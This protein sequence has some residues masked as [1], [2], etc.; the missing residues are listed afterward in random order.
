MDDLKS[1]VE[2][3]EQALRSIEDQLGR[4]VEN[5]DKLDRKGSSSRPSLH[6]QL[7]SCSINGCSCF[8]CSPR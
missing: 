3:H 8:F 1:I 7:S 6:T 2:Y 5:L 4:V